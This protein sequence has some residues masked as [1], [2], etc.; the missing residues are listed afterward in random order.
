MDFRIETPPRSMQ[1]HP[2]HLPGDV[3]VERQIQPKEAFNG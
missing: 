2:T 3:I 1:A